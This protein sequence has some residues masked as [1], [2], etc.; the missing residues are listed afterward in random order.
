[1]LGELLENLIRLIL[2]YRCIFCNNHIIFF[3]F[4]NDEV[5]IIRILHKK[6]N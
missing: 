5:H 2:S 4:G 6:K 1:M 3:K